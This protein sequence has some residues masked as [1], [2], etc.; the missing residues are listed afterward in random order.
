LISTRKAVFFISDTTVVVTL[1]RPYFLPFILI[2]PYFIFLLMALRL[3]FDILFNL[4]FIILPRFASPLVP[5]PHRESLAA[6]A[7]IV[8]HL[9]GFYGFSCKFSSHIC[10]NL[11]ASLLI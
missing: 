1:F 9:L 11:Y 8:L 2:L 10:L 6:S 4:F 5:L 7:V 3:L